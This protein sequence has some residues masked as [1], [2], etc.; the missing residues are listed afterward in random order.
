MH[1]F[2]VAA[3]AASLLLLAAA[4]AGA[5]AGTTLSGFADIQHN[6]HDSDY[7][8]GNFRASGELDVRHTAGVGT[9]MIL[10]LDVVNALNTSAEDDIQSGTTADGSSDG[11]GVDVEQLA[12]RIPVV[13]TVR[14]TAGI[15]NAGFGREGQDAPDIPFAAGGLLWRHVPSNIAGAVLGLTPTDALSI[16]FG[17]IN[18]WTR[19]T[20]ATD[21]AKQ[22]GYLVTTTVKPDAGMTL[23]AGY[24]STQDAA[25]GDL[26]NLHAVL[27]GG[28]RLA[29][30]A[31][32]Q[33]ADPGAGSGGFDTGWGVQATHRSGGVTTALRHESARFEGAAPDRTDTSAAVAYALSD[34]DTLRLD[35]THRDMD[36]DGGRDTGTLQ[37]LHAF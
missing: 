33:A 18:D 21:Q 1:R 9:Q 8:D 34:A 24:V 2:A 16:T 31:E 25:V 5:E 11:V 12:I 3:V 10:D 14:F 4:G 26:F 30:A 35:W 32:F 29:L 28:G 19:P 20:P 37:L 7:E 36:T 22:S 6:T 23:A 13:D 15:Q 17:F 27:E